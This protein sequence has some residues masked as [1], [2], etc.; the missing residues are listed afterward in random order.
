MSEL[1]DSYKTVGHFPTI[2]HISP[3]FEYNF[4][5]SRNNK[6]SHLLEYLFHLIFVSACSFYLL[7]GPILYV[8][9]SKD[10]HYSSFLA[11][12]WCNLGLSLVYILVRYW[13]FWPHML[14]ILPYLSLHIACLLFSGSQFQ[15]CFGLKFYHFMSAL[16]ACFTFLTPNFTISLSQIWAILSLGLTTYIWPFL[17]PNFIHF[18]QQILYRNLSFVVCFQFWVNDFRTK[19][20]YLHD[21]PFGTTL[22]FWSWPLTFCPLFVRK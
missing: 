3:W 5:H 9:L 21:Y 2:C 10:Y 18:V 14:A 20:L 7:S 17:T 1:V 13:L 16:I 11:L 6:S 12:L 19:Y 22:S 4:S 15:N 8:C